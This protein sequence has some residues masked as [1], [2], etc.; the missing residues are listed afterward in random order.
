MDQKQ[1]DRKESQDS[2][3]QDLW[4]DYMDSLEE[5]E[6]QPDQSGLSDRVEQ[7]LYN[8]SRE[9][10]RNKTGRNIAVFVSAGVICVTAAIGIAA[11]AFVGSHDYDYDYDYDYDPDNVP[12]IEELDYDAYDYLGRD[13]HV[14]EFIFN[15]TYYYQLP[16]RFGDFD[17]MEM[18]IKKDAFSEGITEVGSE[19]VRL[20][21]LDEYGEAGIDLLVVSPTGE[22]V[23]LEDALIIGLSSGS[24]DITVS[25]FYSYGSRY[26]W[27][28]EDLLE[29]GFEISSYSY[30]DMEEYR[31]ST[32]APEGSGYEYYNLSFQVQDERVSNITML[33]SENDLK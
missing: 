17:L 29:Q 10:R 4:N 7:D 6:K 25:D 11:Y 3:Q 5:E 15:G 26:A 27:I 32:E 8:Y 20:S 23:P 12:V 21:L 2:Y 31:V 24:Y 28:E 19:P 18:R 1:Y 16:M 9:T 13:F 33:L 22:T 14:P 30:P